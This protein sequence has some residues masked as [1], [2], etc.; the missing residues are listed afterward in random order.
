[1]TFFEAAL[2]I[3]EKEGKPLSFKFITEKA[4]TDKLLSHVGKDPEATMYWRLA[5]MA[6]RKGDRKV[7]A[8]EPGTFGLLDWG[9]VED[10]K[11]LEAQVL[12]VPDESELPLRPR[13]RHPIPRT[14]H[15]RLSGRGERRKHQE[16][17]EKRRK[18]QSLPELTFEVLSQAGA[19]MAAVD[20][21]AALR[22]SE[23]VSEDLGTEALLQALREDNRRRQGQ[24][25]KPLFAISEA[26][27]LSLE[28]AGAPGEGVP[29]ELQAAFAQS[30]GMPLEGG[31]EA[32]RVEKAG[33][34]VQRILQQVKEHQRN[35]GRLLRRR[36]GE[37]ELGAAEL[38][39]VA[40]LEGHG[41][42][43]VRVIKRGKEG[44]V[45]T[46]RRRDGL[47]DMRYAVR[48]ITG[49]REIVKADVAD[50]RR[51]LTAHNAHVGVVVGAG[52]VAR[53]AR[54]EAQTA[55]ALMLLW[56]GEALAD[57]L[58]E[59][60][61]G[62]VTHTVEVADVDDAVFRRAREQGD[63]DDKRREERRKER[64]DREERDRAA[65]EAARAAAAPSEPTPAPDDAPAI[66]AEST[67]LPAAAPTEPIPLAAAASSDSAVTVHVDL[68]QAPA[69]APEAPP[70]P[71]E[72][73]P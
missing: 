7:V 22:D 62:A 6:K 31:T 60:K 13:E 14:D 53:D 15:V 18:L 55:G 73:K 37:L 40:L 16:D 8:T 68:S 51:D 72:P 12:P 65:R 28:K 4:V 44:L 36:F 63:L 70:E 66:A 23:K 42:K 56:C 47:L 39:S 41:F 46:G 45:L 34:G 64:E 33:P 21:A 61:V 48:L 67:P 25:R 69:A 17:R 9:I 26:G 35:I 29:V 24:D 20:V 52:E 49:A 50:L 1:M 32:R 54:S 27:E 19:P 38:V 71:Q 11:A 59:K 43:D 3:L 57:K 5:A 10:P 2:H 30:L 58:L